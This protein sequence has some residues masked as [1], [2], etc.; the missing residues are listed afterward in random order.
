[1]LTRMVETKSNNPIEQ[2]GSEPSLLRERRPR[3]CVGIR[4]T[5]ALSDFCDLIAELGEP[6][7]IRFEQSRSLSKNRSAVSSIS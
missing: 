7:G 5:L 4:T 1:M 2:V 3:V 6:I